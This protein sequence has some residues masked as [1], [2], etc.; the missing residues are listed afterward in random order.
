M[1]RYLGKRPFKVRDLAI[2]LCCKLDHI[3]INFFL[4]I[5]LRGRSKEDIIHP[6][7]DCLNHL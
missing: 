4:Y 7:L 5:L 6:V 1:G 2:F 3:I